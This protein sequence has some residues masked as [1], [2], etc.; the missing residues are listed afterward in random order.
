MA[1]TTFTINGAKVAPGTRTTIE[2]PAG[3]LYTHTPM[4]IPVHVIN[5]KRDGPR[6]FLSA[7]IH[8]DEINGVEII[9]RVL[10]LP[11]LKRI[12]GTLIAVPI[13]NVHGLLSHSR[14]LPDRR[15]LNRSFPGSE[16]GS[17]AARIAHLFMEEIVCQS[18]HGID[19]HTGAV[20]RTNLPQI[21]ANLDDEE[22]DKLA[23]A[24]N[25]PVIIS[26]NLRDGSLREAA[27]EHGI[28][29]LLYEAGE[30]LRFDEMAIRAGVKGIVNVMRSLG[31]L[32]PSRGTRKSYKEPVVARSSSWVRASESGILRALIP[33]GGR[34]SKGTLLGV[35]SDPFGEKEAQITSPYSG[36]VIGK[37]NL[38]LVN[39]GDALYHIARFGDIEEIEA[40]VDEFQEDLSDELNR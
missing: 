14:Y 12:K 36:I 4:T 26:S 27:A 28:P 3:R 29:M 16:K 20:H 11:A 17:L 9:R 6:L 33:L 13:V 7:A 8:G 40:K 21:R 2:L 39:E 1:D 34:V 10:T 22:T 38:P 24:F 31:M 5:G 30:A 25:V 32:P 35:V 19:L 15:D 37:T 23:R 18:T